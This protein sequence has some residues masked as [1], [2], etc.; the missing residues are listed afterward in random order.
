M[1]F[2]QTELNTD[3]G[4]GND[5]DL[6]R[7]LTLDTISSIKG[8]GMEMENLAFTDSDGHIVADNMEGNMEKFNGQMTP[9]HQYKTIA[10]SFE[11]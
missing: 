9:G 6:S 3:F 5:D 2:A 8:N 10:T 11:V 1:S 4:Q 7:D